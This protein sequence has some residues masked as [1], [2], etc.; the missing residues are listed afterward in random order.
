MVYDDDT[1]RPNHYELDGEDE[2]SEGSGRVRVPS[3]SV[4]RRI[5]M[6]AEEFGWRS[7]HR[8]HAALDDGDVSVEAV[9]YVLSQARPRRTREY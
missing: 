9:K 3:P 7:A 6:L 8:I 5:I 4:Q 2:Y 1:G